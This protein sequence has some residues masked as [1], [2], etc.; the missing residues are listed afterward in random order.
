MVEARS[1]LE[2][3]LSIYRTLAEHS[4]DKYLPELARTLADLGDLNRDEKRK[5]EA[6]AAYE[7][8]LKLYGDFALKNPDRFE[9][10]RKSVETSIKELE[11]L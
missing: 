7:K 1:A 3:A 5:P 9:S 8:A 6:K 10:A 2:E 4:S 11:I